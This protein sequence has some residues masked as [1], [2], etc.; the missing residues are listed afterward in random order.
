MK[1]LEDMSILV[2]GGGSGIGADCARRFCGRLEPPPYGLPSGRGSLGK[3]LR[4]LPLH[5]D[6]AEEAATARRQD[7]R[8]RSPGP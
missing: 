1:K 3:K 8:A 2:T 4:S 5:A 6:T 7:H